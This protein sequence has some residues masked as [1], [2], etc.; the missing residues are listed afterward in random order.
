MNPCGCELQ[1][2]WLSQYLRK[3]SPYLCVHFFVWFCLVLYLCVF[4]SAF[5]SAA[6]QISTFTDSHGTERTLHPP[7]SPCCFRWTAHLVFMKWGS[8]LSV[9]PPWPTFILLGLWFTVTFQLG[10]R[11]GLVWTLSWNQNKSRL[12]R[13]PMSLFLQSPTDRH[14]LLAEFISLQIFFYYQICQRISNKNSP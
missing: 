2:S 3:L 4:M 13:F 7:P 6:S 11:P 8:K 9:S 1:T 5:L 12:P 14:K 10:R